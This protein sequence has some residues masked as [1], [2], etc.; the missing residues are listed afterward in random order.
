MHINRSTRPDQSNWLKD[1]AEESRRYRVED[2]FERLYMPRQAPHGVPNN[3]LPKLYDFAA[4]RI[5]SAKPLL[6]LE[7][8]VANG[9]SMSRMVQRFSHPQARFIGFDSFEGL[10]EDWIL[11]WDTKPRGT[12][13]MDGKAPGP[14]DT[15]VLF[16]KGWFQNTLPGYLES[17]THEGPA[18]VHYDADLYSST[19]FILATLWHK[20]YEYY[21]IFDEFLGH[22]II[23]LD[24]FSRAFPVELEFYCQ[25]N[26]GGYP[27]QVF[28]H[29][30]RSPMI[31]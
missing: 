24:D 22:E 8:G 9:L 10:P 26:S 20:I 28:G 16:I 19:L 17:L 30:R 14:F 4:E 31:I 3:D 2:A 1:H 25:T 6:Y 7:F 13:S 15:R 29:L 18:L 11:P 21:F 5:G 27:Q 23:A 12:F